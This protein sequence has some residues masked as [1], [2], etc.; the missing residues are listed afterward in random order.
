MGLSKGDG[1]MGFRDFQSFN[2]VLLAKQCWRL[3]NQPDN[4]VRQIIKTKYY[5]HSSILE[6]SVGKRPSFAW[7]S[8]H[9]SCDLLK[10]GLI[11][12]VGNGQKA[13]IWKEKWIP[14]PS[15]HRVTSPP[16]FLDCNSTV[17]ALIDEHTKRWDTQ[18]LEELFINEEAKVIQSIPLSCTHQE[19]IQIW[20]GTKNGLSTMKSAYYIHS[21]MEKIMVAGC[22]SG[23]NM[24]EFWKALWALSVPNVERNF[25]WRSCHDILPTRESLCRRKIISDPTCPICERDVET[26]IHILW[27]C[28]STMDI[29]SVCSRKIQKCFFQST[30]FIQVVEGVFNKCSQEEI[31][32][33]VGLARRIWTRRNEVIHG[34]AFAHPAVLINNMKKANDFF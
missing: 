1:G 4:L 12:G 31:Q 11:W 8:I 17:C 21:E 18:L 16:T 15:T 32:K 5:P 24:R 33:F 3:W 25:L 28:P 27:T 19:D 30:K 6:A 9:N 2:K 22:S 29:W 34:G 20:R 23:E 13:R 7:R 10:E 26:G 14:T